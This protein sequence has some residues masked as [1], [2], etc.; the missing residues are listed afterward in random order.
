[1]QEGC[2]NS[3]CIPLWP[4][5]VTPP[6]WPFLV[7]FRLLPSHATPTKCLTPVLHQY[8]FR[9]ANLGAQNEANVAGCFTPVCLR[10]CLCVRKWVPCCTAQFRKTLKQHLRKQS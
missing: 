9:G 1:M 5:G 8:Y 6:V 10:Q 4:H 3:L 2:Q 7:L